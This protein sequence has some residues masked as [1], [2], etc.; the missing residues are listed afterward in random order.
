MVT[1]S[2]EEERSPFCSEY[3]FFP[4]ILPFPRLRIFPFFRPALGQVR[5]LPLFIVG[6]GLFPTRPG[7]PSFYSLTVHKLCPRR[8]FLFIAPLPSCGRKK[9]FPSTNLVLRSFFFSPPVERF[10]PPCITRLPVW[11]TCRP[12]FS[13]PPPAPL[14]SPPF[15]NRTP[16]RLFDKLVCGSNPTLSLFVFGC[17]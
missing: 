6:Y 11:Y 4:F 15:L 13:G 14:H 9:L 10:F 7:T 2:Y 12:V 1:A 16:D 17:F 8:V 3:F 5:L